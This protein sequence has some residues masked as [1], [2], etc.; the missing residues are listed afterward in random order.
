[1]KG[2]PFDGKGFLLPVRCFFL[3]PA[4]SL[5]L[6]ITFDVCWAGRVPAAV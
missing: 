6:I 2:I 5:A 4:T 3:P 1:M